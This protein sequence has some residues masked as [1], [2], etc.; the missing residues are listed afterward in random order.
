MQL[1]L[2]YIKTDNSLSA[3]SLT[4]GG[5]HKNETELV[6][7]GLAGSI[8]AAGSRDLSVTFV[9]GGQSL[10]EALP[11]TNDTIPQ[12]L[13]LYENQKNVVSALRLEIAPGGIR[14][15]H[16]KD[17]SN[18][19]YSSQPNVTFATPFSSILAWQGRLDLGSIATTQVQPARPNDTI[20]TYIRAMFYNSNTSGQDSTDNMVITDYVNGTWTTSWFPFLRFLLV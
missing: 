8:A 18:D 2:F 6:Q 20:N 10:N 4:D 9:P 7:S 11:D 12:L 13:L 16:W 3:T 19:L 17:V 15:H 5:W 1:V 14:S